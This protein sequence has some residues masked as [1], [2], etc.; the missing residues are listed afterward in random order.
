MSL[1]LLWVLCVWATCVFAQESPLAELTPATPFVASTAPVSQLPAISPAINGHKRLQWLLVENLGIGSLLDNVAV[2]ALDTLVDSPEE[3]NQHWSGFGT[4]IGMVTLNYAVKST[5]EAA[6][7]SLWGED[8]RY[9]RAAGTSTKGRVSYVI[10]SAFLA[11]NRAGNTMPAYSR[12]IAF[13]AS[14]FLSNEWQPKSETAVTDTVLR[15]GLGFLS[16]IGENAWK[17]FIVPRK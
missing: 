8:P 3:Y 10:K 2:G 15:I 16:R 11:R 4:R 6:L 12:F 7:G 1:R 5:M 13:P 9:L 17:E 14:S